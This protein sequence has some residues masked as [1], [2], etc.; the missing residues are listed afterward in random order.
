VLDRD[1]I[2]IKFDHLYGYLGEL[3]QVLPEDFTVYR[4]VEKKRACERLLQVSIEAVI[5]I[6]HLLV[7]GLRL[8][9]AA[10][11][12]DLFD[13]LKEAGIISSDMAEVLKEMKGLRNIL[14]HEYAQIDDRIVYDIASARLTDFETFKQ[15]VLQCLKTTR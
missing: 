12:D 13:K 7:A 6:C 3:R 5:D 4:K 9:I 8:G 1:R 10:E 15:Q 14:V 2:L 11:E